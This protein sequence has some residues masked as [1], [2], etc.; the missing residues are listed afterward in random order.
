[1]WTDAK[2]NVDR[3]GCNVNGLDPMW[4]AAD[5]MGRRPHPLMFREA[6]RS[7]REYPG[8]PV[9]T[10]VYYAIKYLDRGLRWVVLPG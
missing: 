4:K 1:M 7:G 6:R 2:V 9:S 8:I 10:R 5:P 3:V